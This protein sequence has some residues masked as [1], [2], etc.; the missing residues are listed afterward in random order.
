MLRSV[1]VCFWPMRK[2]LDFA[3]YF[4]WVDR[5]LALLVVTNYAEI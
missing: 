1:R 4:N 5:P 2:G 3:A